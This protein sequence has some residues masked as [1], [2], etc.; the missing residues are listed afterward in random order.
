MTR[1]QLLKDNEDIVFQ[2]I[3]AGVLSFQII[4]DIEIFETFQEIPLNN[5]EAKY[6]LL[7]DQYELSAKRI[8]QIIYQMMKLAYK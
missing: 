7:G 8:E 2:F 1:Y 5:N 4:R 6:L 3:K